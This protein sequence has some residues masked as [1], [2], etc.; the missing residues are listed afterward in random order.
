MYIVQVINTSQQTP[1]V[2]YQ[3]LVGEDLEN[4][5]K[6]LV[7]AV[8][9]S[10]PRLAGASV[11]AVVNAIWDVFLKNN[12]SGLYGYQLSQEPREPCVGDYLYIELIGETTSFD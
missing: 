7:Q 6:V 12:K 5:K 3:V 10:L 8:E 11:T 4:V 1:H 2:C 9:L